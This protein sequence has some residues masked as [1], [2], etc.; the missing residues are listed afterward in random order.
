MKNTQ[1]FNPAALLNALRFVIRFPINVIQ[2]LASLMA[3]YL[4]LLG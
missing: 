3:G 4:S 2:Y 1:S